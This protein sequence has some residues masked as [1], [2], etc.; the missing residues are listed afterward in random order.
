[1]REKKPA[2]ARTGDSTLTMGIAAG[3]SGFLLLALLV[4]E[5]GPGLASGGRSQRISS[6]SSEHPGGRPRR[7]G[8][9]DARRP[10]AGE[11]RG[12]GGTE[13]GNSKPGEIDSLSAT[14]SDEVAGW[15][16][17]A[18]G[19]GAAD[20]DLGIDGES[21][22]RQ[23]RRQQAVASVSDVLGHG[24]RPGGLGRPDP[25]AAEAPAPPAGDG[26]VDI[27]DDPVPAE[28]APQDD[29]PILSF[30]DGSE[31]PPAVVPVIDEG[32]RVDSDGARF[33]ADSEFA[34]PVSQL[35]DGAAGSV[36]FW[37]RPDGTV[38]PTTNASLVQLRSR[39][40]FEN[41]LQLWQNGP[42]V[43]LVFADDTGHEA[44]VSFEAETWE[45]GEWRLVTANWGDGENA[46]YVNGRL[47]GRARYEG[48]FHVLP[49]TLLHIGSNYAE[50]SL[51]L[52]GTI[53]GF[54]VYDRPLTPEE[55]AA[56]RARSPG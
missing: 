41:R 5:C 10:P 28:E 19:A 51:S 24:R 3:I 54:R 55:I 2:A 38:E 12:I 47:V 39:Y 9:D 8:S 50:D 52:N 29:E 13:S 16:A 22:A 36:S 35:L 32:V 6:S 46:L 43:R 23:E 7:S 53:N 27:V 30:F 44:N 40:R 49:D 17:P 1:M 31:A 4:H 37:V 48:A 14:D 15:G 20:R 26:W 56:L 45:P 34:V 21:L 11:G 42:N 25:E 33:S 18:I